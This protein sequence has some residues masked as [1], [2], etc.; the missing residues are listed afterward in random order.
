MNLVQ[1]RTSDFWRQSHI[2]IS[3]R[4]KVDLS[5]IRIR[6][7]VTEHIDCCKVVQ[8]VSKG[9]PALSGALDVGCRGLMNLY[10]EVFGMYFLLKKQKE[11]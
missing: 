4:E 2:E 8:S 7:R 10:P 9:D 6:S 3:E 5:W 1:W 11:Q